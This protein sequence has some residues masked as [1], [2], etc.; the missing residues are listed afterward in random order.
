MAD[1][2]DLYV[3]IHAVHR[4]PIDAVVEAGHVDAGEIVAGIRIGSLRSQLRRLRL[5]LSGCGWWLLMLLL[6]HLGGGRGCLQLS[7]NARRHRIRS[8][9]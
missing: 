9:S 2:L 1:V 6:L 5:L 7:W 4:R 3:H 8:I